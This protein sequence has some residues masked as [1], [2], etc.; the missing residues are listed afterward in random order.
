MICK[1]HN[2][3]NPIS[4]INY[5]S[6]PKEGVNTFKTNIDNV[7]KED[8]KEKSKHSIT[9]RKD[10]PEDAL[11]IK[12]LSHKYGMIF[13]NPSDVTVYDVDAMT[14]GF[15]TGVKEVVGYHSFGGGY[16]FKFTDDKGVTGEL[17]I[18]GHGSK[19]LYARP[20]FETKDGLFPT[21]DDMTF[22]QNI[23]KAITMKIETED[24]KENLISGTT[25]DL[26]ITLEFDEK[27]KKANLKELSNILIS[28]LKYS[29]QYQNHKMI[30]L[31]DMEKRLLDE[32]IKE[33]SYN[34]KTITL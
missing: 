9:L 4:K 3:S 12:E 34:L 6:I 5:S 1:I 13:S 2:V 17:V 33:L 26:T 10:N 21:L 22:K 23:L 7:Y 11:K 28:D 31:S 8:I 18:A 14:E 32:H 15:P 27:T 19:D 25:R 30:K 29:Y 24:K 16:T 20:S